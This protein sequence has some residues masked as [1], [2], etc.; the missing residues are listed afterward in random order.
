MNHEGKSREELFTAPEEIVAF[1]QAYYATEFPNDEQRGCPPAE[2]L[3]GA[4]HAG[5]LPNEQLRAHLFNCSECFRSYRS[6]RMG[7]HAR[8]EPAGQ[9]MAWLGATLVSLRAHRMRVAAGV[10]GLFLLGMVT[11]ILLRYSRPDSPAVAVNYSS[12]GDQTVAPPEATDTGTALSVSEPAPSRPRPDRPTAKAS[13]GT[14]RAAARNT[15]PHPSLRVVYVDLKED[16]FLRG[17]D[18]AG[19]GRRVITLLP[20]RQRLRLQMPRGSAAG[21]YTVRVVDAFGK[22]VLTAAARSGGRMLTVELDLRGLS[23]KL[24]RLCLSRDDE[25]PDC[26]LMSVSGRR[27]AL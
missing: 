20:E 17:D 12:R 21:H 9:W 22:S 26:Y 25:A 5:M 13:P 14:T 8:P 6:A 7:L 4:A 3:R 23:A 10:F 15:R 18:N 19:L 27:S 24:Y 16:D 11:V 1:A 2:T